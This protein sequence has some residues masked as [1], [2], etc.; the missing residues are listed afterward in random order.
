MDP[1]RLVPARVYL[2]YSETPVR[3]RDSL[4]DDLED[5]PIRPTAAACAVRTSRKL[6]SKLITSPGGDR[7]EGMARG[8]RAFT[9]V[10]GQAAT[11]ERR[12]ARGML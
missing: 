2:E 5:L 3:W 7:L 8:R 10:C 9:R 11:A 12:G 1:P 4:V 6:V